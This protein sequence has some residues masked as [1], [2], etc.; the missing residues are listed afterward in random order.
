MANFEIYGPKN[1]LTQWDINRKMIVSVMCD[2]VH[3][4]NRLTK[5]ALVC[6]VYD[7]GGQRAVDVPNILLQNS[8]VLEVY[9]YVCNADE[10]YTKVSAMFP[11]TGRPKPEDY[12]YTETEVL[13]WQALDARVKTL[14]HGGASPDAIAK[15]VEEY[16]EENPIEVDDTL[17]KEN[18]AADAKAVGEALDKKAVKTLTINADGAP[19]TGD[20]SASGI[21]IFTIDYSPSDLKKH[22][23]N[24]GNVIIARYNRHY[25][26][27]DATDESARF[28]FIEASDTQVDWYHAVLDTNKAVTITKTTHKS[29]METTSGGAA[30]QIPRIKTLDSR[31][32]PLTWE[33]VDITDI[34]PVY[35]GEVG[36]V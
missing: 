25:E 22:S 33:F 14:E 21:P 31:G 35:N 17:S 2:Q 29:R 28:R 18:V 12:V 27:Y 1:G 16:M 24:G 26:M 23:E 6:E 32:Y 13:N 20:T 3:F 8:E 19:N 9:A 15:A 34:L 4:S 5:K 36:E 10:S 30:G 11:V 7:I